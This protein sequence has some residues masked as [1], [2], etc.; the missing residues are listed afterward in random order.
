MSA[1]LLALAMIVQDTAPQ[2]DKGPLKADFPPARELTPAHD[3]FYEDENRSSPQ[4]RAAIHGFGACVA[5]RS[6][7]LAA[8]TLRRDFTTRGYRASLQRLT[9]ANE[10][11]FRKHGRL[12]SA[13]LLFAGALA[14]QLM[15][16][17]TEPLN[18][19]LARAAL[20]P[21]TR[22]YAVSDQVAI[23]VVRSMPDEAGKLFAT[24]VGGTEEAAALQALAPAVSTCSAPR[25]RLEANAGGLRAILAT[26][27]FRSI[28]GAAFAGLTRRD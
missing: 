15:Q 17:N 18:V 6:S 11:C 12:R 9:R 25:R 23:C 1:I 5:E 7:D 8:E 2:P 16:R 14:E 19:R 21:A 22:A 13:G 26:A 20:Q 28:D 4:A 3:L 27:A 24:E 10:D